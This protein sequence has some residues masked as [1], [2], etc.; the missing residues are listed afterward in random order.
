MC[1]KTLRSPIVMKHS[2]NRE[3]FPNL[4]DYSLRETDGE[5]RLGEGVDGGTIIIL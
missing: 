1:L 3:T 5:E 4:F 2:F